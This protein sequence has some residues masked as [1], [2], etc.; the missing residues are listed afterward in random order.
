M[1]RGGGAQTHRG[2]FND[3]FPTGS[4]PVNKTRLTLGG[5]ERRSLF[6]SMTVFDKTPQI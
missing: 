1:W 3:K 2:C 4:A 5:V 6:I